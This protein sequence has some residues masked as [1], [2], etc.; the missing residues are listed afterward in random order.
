MIQTYQKFFE[1]KGDELLVDVQNIMYQIDDLEL[2]VIDDP[3]EPWGPSDIVRD[4]REKQMIEN[5][6]HGVYSVE[7]N[8]MH[9]IKILIKFSQAFLIKSGTLVNEALQEIE[10]RF[11]DA[12]FDYRKAPVFHGEFWK[13]EYNIYVGKWHHSGPDWGGR[14]TFVSED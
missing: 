3:N 2:R 12:G 6:I 14:H 13:I 7:L 8:N 5:Q 11:Q 1:S 10:S 4:Y 9:Y